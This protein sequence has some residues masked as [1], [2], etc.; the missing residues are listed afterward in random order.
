[1]LSQTN[2]YS[3]QHPI[4]MRNHQL[5][6]VSTTRAGH[7]PVGNF[8]P[9]V[10]LT[11]VAFLTSTRAIGPR[12]NVIAYRGCIEIGGD[13]TCA[14]RATKERDARPCSVVFSSAPRHPHSHA[15][16]LA[17]LVKS[18]RAQVPQRMGS[19]RQSDRVAPDATCTN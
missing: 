10:S 13:C 14:S 19:P 11:P 16:P 1:V 9:L 8:S 15:K 12:I 17:P 2:D 3:Y 4:E 6:G 5:Y 7:V 18:H